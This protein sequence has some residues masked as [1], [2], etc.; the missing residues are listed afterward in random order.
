[1]QKYRTYLQEFSKIMIPLSSDY[2][3]SSIFSLHCGSNIRRQTGPGLAASTAFHRGD[4][5]TA[6]SSAPQLRGHR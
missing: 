2:H 1:M 3:S 4:G 5:E 6:G